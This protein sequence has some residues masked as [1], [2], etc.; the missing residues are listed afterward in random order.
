MWLVGCGREP[1]RPAP[2]L[3]VTVQAA[4]TAANGT[5][6]AYSANVVADVQVDLAFKVNGYIRSILQVKGADGRMR[7]VQA[8]DLVRAGVVLATLKDETYRQNFLRAKSE[9]ENARATLVKAKADYGRY[10]HLLKEGVAARADYDTYKQRADSA[11]AAVDSAQAVMQGAQVD[12]D[13]C[14]LKSPIKGLVLSRSIEVGTLVAPNTVGFQIGDTDRVKVV[15]GVPGSIV[16][17][18]APGSTIPI[19]TAALPGQTFTGTIT[20]VAS[21]ADP[22]TRVFDVEAT[23]LNPD[24]RLR[25]GMIAGLHLASNI[26]SQPLIGVPMRS[27]VRPPDNQKEYAVYVIENKDGKSYAR[28]KTVHI[29]PVVGDQVTIESGLDPGARV[30]VKGSDIVYDGQEV[31][32]VP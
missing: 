12:V 31:S 20:K 10:T 29:G 9:L 8:G 23:I 30:I 19:T 6:G 17:E 13:D 28:M 25:V 26:V 11:L 3:P 22:T 18:I 5:S 7:N 14:K 27:V 21:V 15:F 32:A 4:S 1:I 2:P 16:G 24:G